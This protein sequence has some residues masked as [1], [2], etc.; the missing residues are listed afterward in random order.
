MKDTKNLVEEYLLEQ[1]IIDPKKHLYSFYREDVEW[2]VYKD[3]VDTISYLSYDLIDN[4]IGY[5]FIITVQCQKLKYNINSTF[6]TKS[7]SNTTSGEWEDCPEELKEIF[8]CN[9][10][11]CLKIYG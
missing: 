2:H 5:A 11:D 3:N 10:I 8:L 6:Y 7:F 1:K 9:T 4:S